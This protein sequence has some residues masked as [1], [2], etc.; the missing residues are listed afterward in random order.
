MS[1]EKKYSYERFGSKGQRVGQAVVDIISKEQPTYTVEEILEG[2]GPACA[3]KIRE[4]ASDY[5]DKLKSPFWIYSI[6]GKPLGYAGVDNAVMH[7]CRP[8][9]WMVSMENAMKNH[10]HYSK[11]LWEVNASKGEISLVWNL[12]DIEACKSIMKN[13]GLYDTNLVGWV[14]DY[15]KNGK[16]A[17]AECR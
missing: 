6:F 12:P 11:S 3:D 4:C 16:D 14:K 8:F 5:K 2:M 7:L 9:N 13:P 15:F 1:E 17:I 10:P